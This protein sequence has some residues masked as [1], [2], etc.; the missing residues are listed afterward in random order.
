M[1][2][3]DGDGSIPVSWACVDCGFDT[4]PGCMN[5]EPLRQALSLIRAKQSATQTIDE[6][7]EVYHVREKVWSRARMQPFSGCLCIGCLEKRI[8]RRLKPEDFPRHPFNWMPGTDRL[9]DR[10]GTNTG[11]RLARR[12]GVT[13]KQEYPPTEVRNE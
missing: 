2:A 12:D 1:T 5:R 9:L 7:S 6:H 10:R 11:P 13:T 3:L 8:G 4:A